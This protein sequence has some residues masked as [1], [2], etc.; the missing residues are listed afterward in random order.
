MALFRRDVLQ[1]AEKLVAKGKIEG[2]VK[3]Y[4][5]YLSKSPD[6]TG[7]LNRV[8]DLL[9]R[10]RK[11]DEAIKYYSKTAE[12]YSA[13]GFFVKAIAVF[14]KIHRI[15]PGRLEVHARLAQLYRRQGLVSDARGHYQLLADHH[16]RGHDP[17]SAI[18]VYETL[19]ELEPGNPSHRL[20]LADLHRGQGQPDR[21]AEAYGKIASLMLSHG[22]LDHA[23]QLYE[24]AFQVHPANVEFMADAIRSIHDVGG[25]EHAQRLVQV[26]V[27]LN[28]D[29][30]S[31]AQFA[32]TEPPASTATPSVGAPLEAASLTTSV[33]ED[34][35]PMVAAN[36][37]AAEPP[38]VDE[39]VDA[40]SDSPPLELAPPVEPSPPVEPFPAS[41]AVPAGAQEVAEPEEWAFAPEPQLKDVELEFD[42]DPADD[43]FEPVETGVGTPAD[44]V[45]DEFELIEEPAPLPVAEPATVGLEPL[46]VESELLSEADVFIKYG[47]TQKAVDRLEEVVENAPEHI[48]AHARLVPLL[49]GMGD[50]DGVAQRAA[51]LYAL[52][53]EKRDE[54]WSSLEESLALAGYEIK[55]GAVAWREPSVA[56]TPVQEVEPPMASADDSTGVGEAAAAESLTSTGGSAA[57]EEPAQA[58]EAVEI[59]LDESPSDLGAIF[60]EVAAAAGEIEPHEPG[61]EEE[62]IELEMLDLEVAESSAAEPIET[63]RPEAETPVVEGSEGEAP[64]H[65]EPDVASSAMAMPEG[66]A[67]LVAEQPEPSTDGSVDSVA[68][69][70]RTAVGAPAWLDEVDEGSGGEDLFE[71]EKEFFDLAAE[72]QEALADDPE[73]Q[74]GATSEPAEQ[75]LE[76]IVDGFRKGVAENIAEEDSDTHYNLGI[77]YREMVLLDEAIGEF[78]ISAKDSRFLANSCSMLGLCFR[79][80]GLP[81][82]A[83]KWYSKALDHGEI[84][85]DQR[86]AL[87]YD[88]GLTYETMEEPAA[89]RDAFV[90][91][92][93]V[94]TGYRDVAEKLEQIPG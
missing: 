72:L 43:A 6:D 3:E 25:E 88:L 41:K 22:Q 11:N 81:D 78:Q 18:K 34:S 84:N 74:A 50:H 5:K 13:D 76:D 28:P 24:R 44:G 10:L 9:V 37:P 92:Y 4:K 23:F 30:A 31:L 79:D 17:Q 38:A 73:T 1:T 55:N 33:S 54:A 42:L 15:D 39:A 40:A 48:G 66:E 75:S 67:A 77:A 7:T 35:P 58:A 45:A 26:A 52:S 60:E 27:A 47:L 61:L 12:R 32:T 21:A 56:E 14:K 19:V 2:A 20:R 83:V 62:E 91:V 85:E 71:E 51:S 29:A 63:A 69:E 53:G 8:G 36:E 70:P 59:D 94:N 65:E 90:E 93:G 86:L 89:A 87:L 80:K 46:S 64:D 49:A 82:L 68:A 16:L 57:A